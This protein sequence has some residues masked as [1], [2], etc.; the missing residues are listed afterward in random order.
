VDRRKEIWELVGVVS[1]G[2]GLCGN[3]DHP[4]GLTRIYGDMLEWVRGVVGRYEVGYTKAKN[5]TYL[6]LDLDIA[7]T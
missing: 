2:P 5:S 6:D 7:W 1:F 3:A 4:V